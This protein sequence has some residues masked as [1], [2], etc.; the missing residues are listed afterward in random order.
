MRQFLL[1]FTTLIVLLTTSGV[2]TAQQP[3][4]GGKAVNVNI[5]QVASQIPSNFTQLPGII[6]RI[7]TVT[8]TAAGGLFVIMLLFG[9]LNYV[10]GAGNEES[11][12]KAKGR[13]IDASVGIVITLSA[14]A[15]G[16]YI[17]N[18]F[19]KGGSGRPPAT[20]STAPTQ[21]ISLNVTI[22]DQNGVA[23]QLA[24]ITVNNNLKAQTNANGK[25]TFTL[26]QG[27]KTYNVTIVAPGCT[28]IRNSPM[29]LSGDFAL[30]MDC[31][32]EQ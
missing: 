17:L 25:A 8:I 12:K 11:T 18:Q 28:D 24:S 5:D 4:S 32:P 27:P 22:T 30:S 20:T 21:R 14:W 16:T 31:A 19:Y 6:G 23:V 2:A 3:V 10:T 15:I 26:D 1:S 7:F 9:G 13:I 29:Y